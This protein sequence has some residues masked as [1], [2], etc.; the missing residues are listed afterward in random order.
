M[1]DVETRNLNTEI[2]RPL[3]YLSELEGASDHMA[4]D[5]E[6]DLNLKGVLQELNMLNLNDEDP[7]HDSTIMRILSELLVLPTIASTLDRPEYAELKTK[8]GTI[9][10]TE[11]RV[12][13]RGLQDDLSCANASV[14]QFNPVLT[15]CMGCNTAPYLLG[16]GRQ[17]LVAMHYIVKYLGKEAS[18]LSK[19]LPIVLEARHHVMT[20]RKESDKIED[21]K[22]DGSKF[23]HAVM[24]RVV[25]KGDVEIGAGVAAAIC[26]GHAPSHC[27]E[28]FKYVDSWNAMREA[29]YEY[30]RANPPPAT[31]SFVFKKSA[32]SI[33]AEQKSSDE[34][35]EPVL[36]DP[37]GDEGMVAGAEERHS[38]ST[39]IRIFSVNGEAVE[40]NDSEHYKHRG[41]ELSAMNFIVYS[42]T[43]GIKQYREPSRANEDTDGYASDNYHGSIGV[44]CGVGVDN[45]NSDDDSNRDD[46]DDDDDKADIDTTHM[47]MVDEPKRKVKVKKEAEETR[48]TAGKRRTSKNGE[49]GRHANK[50]FLFDSEHPLSRTHV[51]YAKEKFDCL[52]RAG[53]GRPR[54]SKAPK[55][56]AD[57]SAA[58]LRKQEKAVA[59]YGANLIPW[60]TTVLPKIT[61]PLFKRWMRETRAVANTDEHGDYTFEERLRAKGALQDLN[62]YAHNNQLSKL[63]IDANRIHR[64]R[65]RHLWTDAEQGNYNASLANPEEDDEDGAATARKKAQ[66]EIEKLL[67]AQKSRKFSQQ[68]L[69]I[70]VENE[71]ELMQLAHQHDAASRGLEPDLRDSFTYCHGLPIKVRTSIWDHAGEA[72]N[73]SLAKVT[74]SVP[75]LYTVAEATTVAALLDDDDTAAAPPPPPP[76]PPPTQHAPVGMDLIRDHDAFENKIPAPFLDLTQLEFM[77]EKERWERDHRAAFQRHDAG[78]ITPPLNPEQRAVARRILEELRRVHM[79]NVRRTQGLDP[80]LPTV[81]GFTGLLILGGAGTGKSFMLNSILEVM[82]SENLGTA[83]FTAYMGIAT[84]QLPKPASTIC[85]LFSL[86][87]NNVPHNGNPWKPMTPAQITV[88]ES[89]AGKADVLTLLASD[90]ISCTDTT[91][92]SGINQRLQQ[93][94]GN[95]LPFGGL[96]FIA[97]GDFEQKQPVGGVPLSKALV[98]SSDIEESLMKRLAI[99]K[100]GKTG[101]KRHR[102]ETNSHDFLGAELAKGFEMH[103]L[104]QQMRASDDPE[105]TEFMRQIR[106][107]T[108]EHPVSEALVQSLSVLTAEAIKEHGPALQFAPRGFLSH[109]EVNMLN[110]SQARLWALHTNKP[111]FWWKKELIGTSAEYLTEEETERLYKEERAGLCGFFVEGAPGFTTRNI[112]VA[113]SI[114]NGGS[115]IYDSLTLAD[116]SMATLEECVVNELARRREHGPAWDGILEVEIQIPHS[117]NVRPLLTAK[118][119]K[120]LLET[121][122]SLSATEVI[123]PVL[124]GRNT[125]DFNTTSVWA[126]EYSIPQKIRTKQHEVDLSFARTDFKVQGCT[127]DYFVVGAGVRTKLPYMNLAAFYVLYSRVRLTTHFFVLGIDPKDTAT[128]QHLLALQRPSMQRLFDQ[129]FDEEGYWNNDLARKAALLEVDRVE[130]VHAEKK[131]EKSKKKGKQQH[132][133]KETQGEDQGAKE[134]ESPAASGAKGKKGKGEGEEDTGKGKGRGKARGKGRGKGNVCKVTDSAKG[135]GGEG[136]ADNGCGSAGSSGTAG[137]SKETGTTA[138]TAPQ[139][140]SSTK[141]GGPSE[142]AQEGQGTEGRGNGANKATQHIAAPQGLRNLG[143]SCYMS[144]VLQ[145]FVSNK[146]L[147]DLL[148]EPATISKNLKFV[149]CFKDTLQS[150]VAGEDATTHEN[151]VILKKSSKEPFTGTTQQDAAQFIDFVVDLLD[152]SSPYRDG[153][154]SQLDAAIHFH[155][156]DHVRCNSCGQTVSSVPQKTHLLQLR[157]PDHNDKV[158]ALCIEDML[159]AFHAP[160]ALQIETGNAYECST[161]QTKTNATRRT[162]L[163]S[164]PPRSIM[165]QFA[166]FDFNTITNASTKTT[167]AATYQEQ[168]TLPFETFGDVVNVHYTLQAVIDHEG[169][170]TS[171]GHYIT[172]ARRSQESTTTTADAA[173]VKD[174]G[175]STT[176]EPHDTVHWFKFDDAVIHHVDKG[177]VFD[178]IHFKKKNGD[179]RTPYILLYQQVSD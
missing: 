27:T 179:V 51:Q 124:V 161:C 28:K 24:Q 9:S 79:N 41:Q 32:E 87:P 101:G 163:T 19:T 21:L 15:E 168:L 85:T 63:E 89:I 104:W 45:D 111:L 152:Y 130:A 166:R 115:V 117:V 107:P 151:Q 131:K 43:I 57:P 55:H 4:M 149:L 96:L 36:L 116:E 91:F 112:K 123:L 132:F 110:Y 164:I 143:N 54:F 61:M 23:A 134:R 153:N 48:G 12:F 172:Y 139:L 137:A 33:I 69:K 88:F 84:Q 6:G 113:K 81:A 37:D 105:R 5:D 60:S 58:W 109:D 122:T 171:S 66:Q 83:A 120:A 13:L 142:G 62:N 75:T 80:V 3:V 108:A 82:R 145:L 156:Q 102:L 40:V 174:A 148:R 64:W 146:S 78:A 16:A 71:A 31:K 98:L 126:A 50:I 175:K 30:G 42:S 7:K 38:E 141:E 92:I 25:I 159:A 119:T 154:P 162:S 150:M 169:R 35:E 94:R 155:M 17:A 8:L 170:D 160:I 10:P 97:S 144:S 44:C 49:A 47:N 121:K 167:T 70:A 114:V 178:P 95:D 118:E 76:P 74:T 157:F 59:Y 176:S 147:R 136:G 106:D 125:V 22:D 173:A 52:M 77:A 18:N 2:K 65:N 133:L 99:F 1:F 46:S 140:K 29:E 138:T 127:F 158:S 20:Y 135:T 39:N 129:G 128:Y 67:E 11:A 56:G 72:A 34:E 93:L 73:S 53:P 90:E 14:V 68:R 103:N 165:I 26:L 100:Q 177:E 86:Y